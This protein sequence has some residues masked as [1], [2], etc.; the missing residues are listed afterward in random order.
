MILNKAVGPYGCGDA[1]NKWFI[2]ASAHP[3]LDFDLQMSHIKC[4]LRI[5]KCANYTNDIFIV[6]LCSFDF[7]L[8]CKHWSW[9]S[10]SL[11]QIIPL[12]QTTPRYLIWMCEIHKWFSHLVLHL[13]QLVISFPHVAHLFLGRDKNLT[14]EHRTTM[15]MCLK[16][17]FLYVDDDYALVYR[18]LRWKNTCGRVGAKI[19]SRPPI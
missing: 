2:S 15:D 18:E 11:Q 14:T 16:C 13:R 12:L 9:P 7:S 5:V 6:I 3:K 19:K 8:V 10:H 4:E 17:W 1:W